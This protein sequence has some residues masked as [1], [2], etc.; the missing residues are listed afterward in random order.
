MGRCDRLFSFAEPGHSPR[1]GRTREAPLTAI[2]TDH[3]LMSPNTCPIGGA[4]CHLGNANTTIVPLAAAEGAR[5]GPQ[6]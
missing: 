1:S 2:S 6:R 5:A 3:S 4:F